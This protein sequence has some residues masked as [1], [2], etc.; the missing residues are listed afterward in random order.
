MRKW[1]PDLVFMCESKLLD[2]QAN[3]L[4]RLIGFPNLFAVNRVGLSGG[5]VLMWRDGV[6]VNII[7]S[8]HFYIDATISYQGFLPWPFFGIY[9]D[10]DS[11]Q[12]QGTSY[13]DF[14][15]MVLALGF[16]GE[17][18]MRFLRMVKRMMA[19][20]RLNNGLMSSDILLMFVNFVIWV[21]NGII[22]LVI[23]ADMM[24]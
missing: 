2:W 22:I 20:R 5:L 9:G 16:V 21:M 8:S 14:V 19:E 17:I 10:S 24:V 15:V 23:I 12:R 11:F 7:S 4:A 6:M 18:S 3:C 13:V 1:Y